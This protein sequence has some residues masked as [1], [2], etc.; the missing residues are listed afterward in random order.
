M[1]GV[2]CAESAQSFDVCHLSR[3]EAD[4][5]VNNITLLKKVRDK[6]ENDG[7][8]IIYPIPLG[9]KNNI[10]GVWQNVIGDESTCF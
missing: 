5:K 10:Q 8:C 3:D 9:L 7:F 6:L 1:F 4:L 2:C